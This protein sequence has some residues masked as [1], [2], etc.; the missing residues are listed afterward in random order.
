MVYMGLFSQFPMSLKLH[1]KFFKK[2]TNELIKSI[3]GKIT[4]KE[5]LLS[6]VGGT[7]NC[8]LLPHFSSLP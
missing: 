8:Y 4:G 1:L 7:V 5:A 2:T 3:A 6:T